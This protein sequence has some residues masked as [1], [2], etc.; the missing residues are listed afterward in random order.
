[1]NMQGKSETSGHGVLF[2][3]FAVWA[4]FAASFVTFSGA[5]IRPEWLFVPVVAVIGLSIAMSPERI[6]LVAML[7]AVWV[8][9]NAPGL[10]PGELLYYGSF[11]AMIVLV[12]IPDLLLG[13]NTGRTRI[14]SSY[15]IILAAILISLPISWLHG[16]LGAAIEELLYFFSGLAFL[17]PVLNRLHKP[18]FRLYASIILVLVFI[19]IAYRTYSSYAEA[20][21]NAVFQ[22]EVTNARGAG[23]ENTLLLASTTLLSLIILSETRR[24]AWLA[25]LGWLI[26]FGAIIV[27]FTRS[28]WV[29]TVFSLPFIF[30]LMSPDMRRK[31]VK[32]GSAGI[33]LVAGF[34][35]IAY[36]DVLLLFLE[37]VKA[38][39]EFVSANK[40][41]LSLMERVTETKTIVSMLADNP[42]LGYG[43]GTEYLRLEY[44]KDRTYKTSSYIHNGYLSVYFKFGLLG[45][46]GF[47]SLLFGLFKSA[48]TVYRNHSEPWLRVI[49]M[50]AFAYLP[51]AALMNITSP[52]FLS[53]EGVFLLTLLTAALAY[54]LRTLDTVPDNGHNARSAIKA[55]D[56]R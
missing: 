15:W 43:A 46:I 38:R 33:L 55:A 30:Y 6:L 42:I 19:F 14:E 28:L 29:V 53:F 48:L 23:N 16:H 39:F 21:L 35:V 47:T 2:W 41:D 56:S 44:L 45:L 52:V 7:S 25:A 27:T 1:M 9:R 50:G 10:H 4:L 17:Y 11:A 3:T 24:T 12:W 22:Y 54:G 5:S 13:R 40:I 31:V 49:A 51:G 20:I 37:L 8:F 34:L 36:S 18:R 32:A 26:C